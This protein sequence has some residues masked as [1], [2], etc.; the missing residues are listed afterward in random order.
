MKTLL[1]AATILLLATG[2]TAQEGDAAAEE[3]PRN[4]QMVLETTEG[5]IV[6]ELYPDK[7]PISVEN[8]IQY[9]EDGFYDGTIFHRVVPGFMV[10]GGGFM[11]D[12]TKK[13]T[14]ERIQNEADNGLKNVRGTVALARLSDPHSASA[15]FFVNLVYNDN[16]DHRS[17]TERGWGYTVFG[18]VVGDGMKTIDRISRIRT[19]TLKGYKNVPVLPV[20]IQRAYMREAPAG[21]IAE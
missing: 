5:D 4:P 11:E 15:Q 12:M 18:Q 3:S 20:T 14:R 10:Q 9:V 21:D 7:A 13:E 16:L 1:S 8:V 2:L 6:I 19:R 17:K